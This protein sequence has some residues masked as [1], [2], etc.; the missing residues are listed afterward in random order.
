M[1]NLVIK[2]RVSGS[3]CPQKVAF[4]YCSCAI[5]VLETSGG[6]ACLLVLRFFSTARIA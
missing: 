3:K 1:H 6:F 4:T 5:V 2:F